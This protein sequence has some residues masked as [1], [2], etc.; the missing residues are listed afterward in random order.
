MV[1]FPHTWRNAWN[2]WD[3]RV[4]VLTSLLLQILLVIFAPL[5]KRKA[6][7]SF[8][9]FIWST[10]LLADWV[11]TLALG[12]LCNSQGDSDCDNNA[13]PT[14][15][16]NINTNPVTGSKQNNPGIMYNDKL[17]AFWAPF[18]LLHLG[19]PDAITAFA[20]E[21]NELWPRHLVGFLFE[22]GVAVYAFLLSIPNNPLLAPTL[23]MFL[24]GVIKYGER[25]YAL[26]L[27]S[28]DGF[29]DTLLHEPDP[30]MDYGKLIDDKAYMAECG[31]TVKIYINQQPIKQT[32]S[33]REEKAVKAG[34]TAPCASDFHLLLEAH[35]F[36]NKFKGIM[37]DL[38]LSFQYLE[39]SRQKI[40]KSGA[41]D[42]FRVIEFELGFLYELF[43]TKAVVVHQRYGYIL[44]AICSC[45]IMA[46]FLSF[47][48]ILRRQKFSDIDIYIT[49]TLLGGAICL[50]ACSFVMFI[51]SDLTIVKLQDSPSCKPISNFILKIRPHDRWSLLATQHSLMDYC[52]PA[53][54]SSFFRRIMDRPTL[55]GKVDELLFIQKIFRLMGTGTLLVDEIQYTC[56]ENVTEEN[57]EQIFAQ[58]KSMAEEVHDPREDGHIFSY[59]GEWALQ[60]RGYLNEFKDSIVDVEFDKSLLMWHIAT[61]FCYY[62][63]DKE[64]YGAISITESTHR[65]FCKLLSDYLMYL[66]VMRPQMMSTAA[67]TGKL[68]YLDTCD[69]IKKFFHRRLTEVDLPSRERNE[70]H[71]L[72]CDHLLSVDTSVDPKNIK[73]EKNKSVL[74]DACVLAKNLKTNMNGLKRWKIMSEVWIEMLT[75]A[76][77]RCPGIAHAQRLSKGGELLTFV[78]F[79]MTHLGLV[80][81]FR[82]GKDKPRAK[83]IVTKL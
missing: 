4:F 57:K 49:Y 41:L 65:K 12:L 47:F 81:Q 38:L 1:N 55:L 64:E 70:L 75:Y 71:K 48:F 69:D 2:E 18:L 73:G 58:L 20:M 30:G 61:D 7:K 19:G 37:A 80:E 8:A 24:A 46:A 14:G 15:S 78:W 60:R 56:R 26:Y 31:V 40:L 54:S 25:K 39:E 21:D 68:R 28:M 59:P 77:S 79:L 33:T 36:F 45:S 53:K 76:A 50:D 32:E 3:I 72:A 23:L 42:V 62:G 63:D 5:R 67:V 22:V 35:K 11:A 52:I 44:R 82:V 29:R 74:F 10:Y 16:S 43:F 17:L 27:G 13:H 6:S 51:F 9:L 83:L 66:L 34:A